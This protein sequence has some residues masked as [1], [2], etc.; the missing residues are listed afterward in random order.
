[1][2]IFV[3]LESHRDLEPKRGELARTNRGCEYWDPFSAIR[4][5]CRA[6]RPLS[7]CNILGGPGY[8]LPMV[9]GHRISSRWYLG[10][11]EG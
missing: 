5:R 6:I 2:S 1:M 8:L 10:H 9:E 4:G 7:K 3:P 11:L